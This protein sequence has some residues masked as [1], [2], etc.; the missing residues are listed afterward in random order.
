MTPLD[1]FSFRNIRRS[2]LLIPGL[3]FI[4]V[5]L[6]YDY[7]FYHVNTSKL[8]FV[9]GGVTL[10]FLLSDILAFRK[11]N[12]GAKDKK[13]WLVMGIVAFPLLGMLPGFMLHGG[14]FNYYLPIEVSST[15]ILILWVGYLFKRT[16]SSLDLEVFVF[17]LSLTSIYCSLWAFLEKTGYH[18]KYTQ[19]IDRVAATHGNTNYFSGFLILLLPLF[20]ARG[21]PLYE[22]S[23]G[24]CF[25]QRLVYSKFQGYYLLTF[26][27]GVLSLYWASSR[28]AIAGFGMSLLVFIFL[29]LHFFFASGVKKT[30]VL[31]GIIIL[32][33]GAGFIGVVFLEKG[34]LFSKI[35]ELTM[36]SEWEERFVSW[37]PAIASIREAPW[38]GYGPGSSYN[39]FFQFVEPMTRIR[40]DFRRFNHVHLELLEIMQEGGVLSLAGFL[41]LWGIVYWKLLKIIFNSQ[42][43][44]FFKL[45]AI[46]VFCGTLAHH[47]QSFFSVASRMMVVKLPLYSMIGLSFILDYLQKSQDIAEKKDDLSQ[48]ITWKKHVFANLVPTLCLLTICWGLLIPWAQAMYHYTEVHAQARNLRDLTFKLEKLMKTQPNIYGLQKLAKLQFQTKRPD[49]DKIW[50]MADALIPHYDMMDYFRALY[51]YEQGA[52]ETAY[53]LAK[54]AQARDIYNDDIIEMVAHFAAIKKDGPEFSRQLELMIEKILLYEDILRDHDP[55]KVTSTLVEM[56]PDSFE[57]IQKGDSVQMT[58]RQDLIESLMLGVG[59]REPQSIAGY[60]ERK[61]FRQLLKQQL[62]RSHFFQLTYRQEFSPAEKAGY[63]NNWIKLNELDEDYASKS[64]QNELRHRY[65]IAQVP[66]ENIKQL[67]EQYLK[68]TKIFEEQYQEKR[69]SY[70]ELLMKN[71]YWEEFQTHISILKKILLTIDGWVKIDPRE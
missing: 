19:A 54:E 28:A 27:L 40:L 8:L 24:N 38:F 48:A 63:Q 14:K 65:E 16:Q 68:Q 9:C 62:G 59:S 36:T 51:F 4:T 20:L 71:T 60:E 44:R 22:P 31:T 50:V 7:T 2:P 6:W 46:G 34:L 66:S 18:P 1:S 32:I 11:Y 21:L 69:K 10:L 43:H 17:A 42:G 12:K 64:K 52:L 39:L 45:M 33:I 49:L 41:F 29:Y 55:A 57:M 70:R 47:G 26:C 58:W 13:H 35:N 56:A 15:L 25:R 37:R 61:R 53:R 5:N 67:K 3:L 30:L 23:K